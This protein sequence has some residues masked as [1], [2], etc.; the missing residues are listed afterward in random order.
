[1]DAR[2]CH[3]GVDRLCANREATAASQS[4]S[5]GNELFSRHRSASLAGKLAIDG[6]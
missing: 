1:M 3:V 4:D 2:C 6:R 5:D